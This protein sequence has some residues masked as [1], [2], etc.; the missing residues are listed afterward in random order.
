MT[1]FTTFLQY[2]LTSFLFFACF[3]ATLRTL[4]V[5]ISH[6]LNCFLVS[7]DVVIKFCVNQNN[8]NNNNNNNNELFDSSH[9]Y[10]VYLCVGNQTTSPLA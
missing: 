10:Y 9:L 1:V 3:S 6:F 8:N 5:A 7:S 4:S 2:E